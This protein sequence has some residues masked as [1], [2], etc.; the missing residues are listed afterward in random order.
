M[1]RTNS[2][3]DFTMFG[4]VL[5]AIFK[6]VWLVAAHGKF[7]AWHQIEVCSDSGNEL[8]QIMH[9]SMCRGMQIDATADTPSCLLLP[10][11]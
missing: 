2:W 8:M 3:H 1:A 11:G 10:A 6:C 7:P 9:A 4:L 5:L